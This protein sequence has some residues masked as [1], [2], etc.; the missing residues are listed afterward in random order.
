M[1]TFLAVGTLALLTTLA[2][3]QK[4]NDVVVKKDGS[5][6]R[7]VEV[8]EFGLAGIKIKRGNDASEIPPHQVLD[9]EWSDPPEA[10]LSAKAAWGRG[11]FAAAAQ[12]FGEAANRT[13]RAVLK[14]D[15]R[16]HQC[17]AAIAAAGT[18]QSAATTAAGSI[19]GWIGE[20]PNHWR[21]PEALLLQGRSQRLAGAG[22]DAESTLRELDSRATRDGWGSL[23]SARAKFEMAL[24]QLGQNKAGDARSSFQAASSAADSALMSP[25]GDEAELR[26]LKTNAKVGEGE[27]YIGEKDYARA[28]EF[29]RRLAGAEEPELAAAGRAGEGQALYLTAS[30]SKKA[31]DLRRAQLALSQAS[32]LDTTSGEASAKA[33]YYLGMVL[34]ALGAERE[35]DSFR[36]RA[37]AYFQI[38][39]KNYSTSPW[40]ALARAELTR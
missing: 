17:K 10:Y 39:A 23:W 3:A 34:L 30:T 14:A 8:T 1:R 32:V 21:L 26:A 35:G 31:E 18:D 12:L 11:D 27:T 33:N 19:R 22:A 37:M 9:I 36:N 28:L 40:A 20:N 5:R 6:V 13:D 7:G 25:G 29:F 16:F 38:V 2:Q 4:I 15:A 24:A